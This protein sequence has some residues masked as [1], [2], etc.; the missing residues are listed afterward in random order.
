MS[1]NLLEMRIFVRVMMSG[2]LSRAA[3][4]TGLSLT[5]ISRK[6][7]RLEDRLGVRLINRTTRSLSATEE[8][9]RFYERCSRILDEIDE[10]EAEV[11]S[12]SETATGLLK[13]TTTFAFGS[14]W[15]VPL[16]EEF[17]QQ[18]PN[19]VLQLDTN[20]GIANIVESG[21]DLAIRFGELSDSSLIARRLASNRR[22]ICGAPSYLAKRGRPVTIEDLVAH[23]AI[24]FGEPMNTQWSFV[25][26]RVVNVNWKIALNNGELAH[27]SALRGHGLVLKSIWDVEDDVRSGRLEIV[28]PEVSALAAPLHAVYPHNRLSAAK[29]RLCIDFLA[30]RLKL[31]QAQ[32]DYEL[33]GRSRS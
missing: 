17:Q 14:R 3:R 4:D 33:R 24:V 8:G 29:L 6:L 25:D 26:D 19:L 5:V 7:S 15:L 16:M 1:D 32:F 20:D 23:D 13:I 31:A 10:A 28:L 30:D 2:S 18:H 21:Y 11:S 12:G 27:Q 22:V 9:Q